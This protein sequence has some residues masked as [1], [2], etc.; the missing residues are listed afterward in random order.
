MGGKRGYG[1]R[2]GSG[3]LTEGE[4]WIGRPKTVHQHDGIS[5]ESGKPTRRA[6]QY[7]P[8]RIISPT[9]CTKSKSRKH[10]CRVSI[11]SSIFRAT[12][13]CSSNA[14]FSYQQWSQ[15][16]FKT[17]ARDF[18]REWAHTFS[19]KALP[20]SPICPSSSPIRRLRCTVPCRI[21]NKVDTDPTNSC[22]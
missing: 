4:G 19:P 22:R 15:C 6:P 12:F 2:M 8:S 11:A 17:Y 13:F 14:R 9:R 16:R 18:P 7:F 20:T 10:V 5:P 3:I 21:F 1:R